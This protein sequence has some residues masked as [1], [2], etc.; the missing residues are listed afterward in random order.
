[1]WSVHKDTITYRL[2]V[3][4]Q[5]PPGHSFC[6]ETDS[7]KQLPARP[8]IIRVVQECTCSREQRLGLNVCFLHNTN[9]QLRDQ[10][11]HLLHTLCT[12]SYL[13]VEKTACWV[14]MLVRS[15]WQYLPQSCSCQLTMLPSSRSCKFLM[16]ST[17]K[18]NI[19][20]EMKFAVQHGSSGAY[21][22][23]ES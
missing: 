6:L 20:T 10:S 21:L 8:S 4:L 15:A 1:D 16:T 14:Q 7:T 18:M 17:S 22:N 11:L 5:P 23:L 13:D 12:D 3:F 19:C 9:D 2:L